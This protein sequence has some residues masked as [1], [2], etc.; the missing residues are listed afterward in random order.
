VCPGDN[1]P[2]LA[3]NVPLAEPDHA[4]RVHLEGEAVRY[5]LAR[6]DDLLA[7]DCSEERVDRGVYLLLAELAAQV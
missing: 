4:L 2:A 1:R 6:G 7:A 3:V 5:F